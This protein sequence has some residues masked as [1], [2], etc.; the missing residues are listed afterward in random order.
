[1]PRSRGTNTIR[2][3]TDQ[4]QQLEANY[5]QLKASNFALAQLLVQLVHSLHNQEHCMR[6]CGELLSIANTMN[7]VIRQRQQIISGAEERGV[8]RIIINVHRNQIRKF[9]ADDDDDDQPRR[10]V[11]RET[12]EV[13]IESDPNLAAQL[14][15]LFFLTDRAAI[16]MR[17]RFLGTST[18]LSAQ[19]E[20]LTKINAA[21]S[22]QH[23]HF[24]EETGQSATIEIRIDG[25]LSTTNL[26]AKNRPKPLTD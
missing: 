20:R 18:M 25:K 23:R 5:Y 14:K 26:S 3:D 2:F 9:D 8:N 4:E 13:I 15:S 7:A 21:L 11:K 16:E 1:M 10:P 12:P 22:R 17:K 6:I 24:E 19:I